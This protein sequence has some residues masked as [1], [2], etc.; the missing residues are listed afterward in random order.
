LATGHMTYLQ[1][2]EEFRRRIIVSAIALVVAFGVSWLFAWDILDILKKP[3]GSLNLYYM[4]PMEPFMV[5]FKLAIFG[6]ILLALPVILF[7]ILAFVSPA[8]K[9]KERTYT[10]VILGMIVAFFA[11]GVYFGWKFIMP[12]GIRWLFSVAEGQMRSVM[13]ASSYVNF[14]G[15]FMLGLGVSFETPVFIWM[16]VALRVVQP[17]QLKNQWRWALVIILLVAA[18]ITPDWSPVTMVLVA[19]P[20]AIL[21]VISIGLAYFTTRKRRAREEAEAIDVEAA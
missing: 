16:L 21:Y 5:R 11:V 7:E 3:A 13:S 15:W 12:P 4:T 10:F 6:A 14:A 9:R 8:L 2:L 20:M 18:V 17:E 19:L 1:H